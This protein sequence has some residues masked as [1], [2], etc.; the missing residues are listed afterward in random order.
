MGLLVTPQPHLSIEN[1][2]SFVAQ[3]GLSV[4]SHETLPIFLELLMLSQWQPVTRLVCEVKHWAGIRGIWF[5]FCVCEGDTYWLYVLEQ[6]TKFHI[7]SF[8]VQWK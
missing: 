6:S 8:S 3:G 2:D 7:L 4:P 1:P 5:K